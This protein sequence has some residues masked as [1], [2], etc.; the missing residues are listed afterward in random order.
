MG[1]RQRTA[2]KALG[3]RAAQLAGGQIIA[4][5]RL[6]ILARLLA[7]DAFGIVAVGVATLALV[8]GVS[9]LGLRQALIQHDGPDDLTYDVAWTMGLVRAA[10]VTVLVVL[11]APAAATL[12]GEPGAT[13]IIRLLALRPLIDA[14]ASI[15]VARATRELAFR[16][17]A[18]MALPASV[19]DASVAVALASSI[20]AW[21]IVVGTLTGAALQTVL[22]YVLAPHRPRLLFDWRTAASLVQFGRWILL[23]GIVALAASSLSQLGISRLLGAAALGY[24]VVAA[25]VAFLPYDA[26]SAVVGAVAFPLYA[27]YRGDRERTAAAFGTL[28]A[29]QMLLLL[30]LS[31]VIVALAPTFEEALGG[32]WLGT[33]PIM[34]VLTATCIVGLFGDTVT[35]LL[36]GQGRARQAFTIDALQTAV[37]LSLLVPLLLALGVVGVAVARLGGVLVAQVASAVFV[38]EI[39]GRSLSPLVRRQILAALVASGSAILA[40]LALRDV[41]DG[42]PALVLSGLAAVAAAGVSLWIL[43]RFLPL[44]LRQLLPWDPEWRLPAPV[45]PDVLEPVLPDAVSSP[46]G[47]RP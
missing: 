19:L 36:L 16:R 11:L 9:N 22:S 26:A 17:L 15:G 40:A 2:S 45:A 24:Y 28:L 25:R 18:L 13:G 44:Q 5:L 10:G 14:A 42:L 30:P 46:S 31:A 37:Q 12:F 20:G 38:R 47:I 32:Q 23:T 41:L 34:Q 1:I 29:S 6:L 43:D 27:S 3:W 35:P 7:P 21:A 39:A 8:M 4:L 33:A